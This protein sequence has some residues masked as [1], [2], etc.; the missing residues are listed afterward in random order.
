MS[1]EVSKQMM[2]SIAADYERLAER[3]ALRAQSAS[4]RPQRAHPRRA[5]SA[6]RGG[7][8]SGFCPDP[9]HRLPLTGSLLCAPWWEKKEA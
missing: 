7:R 6:A 8:R 3:A 2:L 4:A 1:D 9:P 5:S